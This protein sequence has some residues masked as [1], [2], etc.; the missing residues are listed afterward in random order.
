MRREMRHMAK[1][2]PEGKLG[3]KARKELNRQR[4]VTWEFS[5]VTRTVESRKLYNRKK[6]ARDRYDDSGTG[7]FCFVFFG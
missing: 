7:V 4:R 2:V 6:N 1:F 5:P 3:R